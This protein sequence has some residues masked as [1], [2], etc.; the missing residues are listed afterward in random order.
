MGGL[1]REDGEAIMF[2]WQLR[3][4]TH[5]SNDRCDVLC[6]ALKHP[7]I[8]ITFCASGSRDQVLNFH[9]SSPAGS[10]LPDLHSPSISNGLSLGLCLQLPPSC[11]TQSGFGFSDQ[12]PTDAL[13]TGV[14]AIRIEKC[15]SIAEGR[16]WLP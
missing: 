3:A 6:A 15:A 7:L 10:D 8:I 4:C 14:K 11:N 2:W 5:I 1:E 9:I 12:T 16:H 13:T